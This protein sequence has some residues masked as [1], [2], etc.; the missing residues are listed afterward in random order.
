MSSFFINLDKIFLKEKFFFKVFI[1]RQYLKFFQ[2]SQISNFLMTPRL[3]SD[4]PLPLYS[5]ISFTCKNKISHHP[6]CKKNSKSRYRSQTGPHNYVTG[7]NGK[8][9]QRTYPPLNRTSTI[10]TKGRIIPL[11]TR[12]P[13]A[14]FFNPHRTTVLL[15]RTGEGRAQRG[16]TAACQFAG[17]MSCPLRWQ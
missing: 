6:A 11:N 16:G 7:A 3:I 17:G 15:R 2:V 12:Q 9:S 14:P 4:L 1:P 8:E 10:L 13:A 5:C